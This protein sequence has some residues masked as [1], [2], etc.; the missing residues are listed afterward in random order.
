MGLYKFRSNSDLC[1]TGYRRQILPG[2][3]AYGIQ[4]DLNLYFWEYKFRSN[5]DLCLTGYRRQILPGVFAYGIQFDL[6]LY[7]WDTAPCPL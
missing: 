5:S 7:F 3:F 1:L 6:N 2:V 4:F